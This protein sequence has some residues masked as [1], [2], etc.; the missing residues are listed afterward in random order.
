MGLGCDPSSIMAVYVPLS[1]IPP[2]SSRPVDG[3]KVARL[4]GLVGVVEAL[5]PFGF[6]KERRWWVLCGIAALVMRDGAQG[7]SS[8][9]GAWEIV[10]LA[11]FSM[12][13][14]MMR[15]EFTSAV[16]MGAGRFRGC[17]RLPTFRTWGEEHSFFWCIMVGISK[18][19]CYKNT[20]CI[21]SLLLRLCQRK[22]SK[23]INIS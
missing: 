7:L 20:N 19:G 9:G 10:R 14:K 11:L 6:A 1:Q 23:F 16:G 5:A 21:I 22:N 12:E 8:F 2:N 18:N 4:P 13:G 3:R 15:L 17:K